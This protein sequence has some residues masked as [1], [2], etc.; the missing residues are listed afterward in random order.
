MALSKKHYL[1]LI[2]ILILWS[3]NVIA[4]KLAVTELPPLTAATIRF[5][6]AGMIFLP[7]IKWPGRQTFWTI[8]QIAILMNVLHIGLLFIGLKMLDASSVAVLLQTQVLFA[9]V[10][11]IIFFK[12]KIR[13]KTWTGMGI[14]LLGII[15]MMGAPNLSENPTGV[16]IMLAS[17]LALSF[18]YVKMK[19]LQAVHPATYICLISLLATPFAFAASLALDA[20]S[21]VHL[22]DANWHILIPVFAYQSFLISLTHIGWQKLMARG[23]VGRITAFTLVSPFLI[24]IMSVIFLGETIAMP[25]VI[26]GIVTMVGVGII[27]IRRM[28]KGLET[29]PIE[30]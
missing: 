10:L 13:W 24:A 4:I 8:A 25:M 9:T 1:A 27:T 28:Q 12:E 26:G 30:P 7:F 21:W 17:C 20:Q 5:A 11:G 15:I 2:G 18:S 3:G 29:P 22:P 19:H 6:L 16:A 23:D 14:A